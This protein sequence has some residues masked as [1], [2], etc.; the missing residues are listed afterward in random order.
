[1]NRFANTR[2][3]LHGLGSAA[4]GTAASSVSAM[5]AAPETFNFSHAGLAK[6][7][8]ISAASAFFAAVLYLKQSPLPV[9]SVTVTETASKTVTVTPEDT[10]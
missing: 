3:W 2:I 4:I 10:K 9:S 8:Q 1:M 5:W 6:L 7:G